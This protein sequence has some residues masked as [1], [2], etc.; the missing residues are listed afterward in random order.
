M[1]DI[2]E[3]SVF[4]G[5]ITAS[6][7][8]KW[9]V[10]SLSVN[11]QGWIGTDFT[12]SRLTDRPVLHSEMSIKNLPTPDWMNTPHAGLSLVF[13][14]NSQREETWPLL[15]FP[16]TI[17]QFQNKFEIRD[18][19]CSCRTNLQFTSI[20]VLLLSF[21]W[22][23]FKHF[24]I[25]QTSKTPD[26]FNVESLEMERPAVWVR[27]LWLVGVYEQTASLRCNNLHHK[28]A[29]RKHKWKSPFSHNCFLSKS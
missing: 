14:S 9:L 10:C 15:N 19:P 12:P 17:H 3:N 24:T 6:L 4:L 29:E 7:Q 5:P 27:L 20:K 11:W 8:L 18:R 25:E 23:N 21:P 16:S 22:V 13:V 28:Q 1:L 26:L 2:G